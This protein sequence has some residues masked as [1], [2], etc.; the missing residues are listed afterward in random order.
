MGYDQDFFLWTSEQATA[1]RAAAH[2]GAN[3]PIDW[4]N[5]AEEIESLGRSDRREIASRIATIVEH[6]MKLQSSPAADPRSGWRATVL[7]ERA[8]IAD[9]LD[10]SPS[11]RPQL[12][13]II[14]RA[15]ATSRQIVSEQLAAYG[16]QLGDV[17]D[18]T[19]EQVLG[20]WFPPTLGK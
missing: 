12:A 17:A 16:E 14:G 4:E 5:V 1:L 15:M 6:L 3:L 20:D 2:S 10:D 13:T 7:R 9:L 11:L 19:E 18:Y 8:K